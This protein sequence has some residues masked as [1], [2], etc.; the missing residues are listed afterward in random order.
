MCCLTCPAVIADGGRSFTEQVRH[1]IRP[2]LSGA[3][4]YVPYTDVK[5]FDLPTSR[6]RMLRVLTS[7]RCEDCSA[8]SAAFTC[9]PSLHKPA[10]FAGFRGGGQE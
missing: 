8:S 1:G 5:N 9:G 2:S 4:P 6:T 3:R 10:R 7:S